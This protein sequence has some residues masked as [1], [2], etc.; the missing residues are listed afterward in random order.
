L[1]IKLKFSLNTILTNYGV[2]IKVKFNHEKVNREFIFDKGFT[3]D[4]L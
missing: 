4:K 2:S 1:T 3:D